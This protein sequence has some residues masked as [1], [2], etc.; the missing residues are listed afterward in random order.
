MN[1]NKIIKIIVAVLA[2]IGVFLFVKVAMIG[3]DIED[4][5]IFAAVSNAT[6]PLITFSIVLVGLAVIVTVFFSILSIFKTPGA[7]KKS[8]ISLGVLAGL[9]FL[10][11]ALAS[12]AEVTDTYGLALKDGIGAEGAVPKRVGAM[13]KYTYIL[14]AIALGT[15]VWGSLK[16]MFSK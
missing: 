10:A 7:L 6:H 2:L 5:E 9:F 12:N 1:I 16:E 8:L 13:I 11:Y 15:V 14:G 4:P 3:G